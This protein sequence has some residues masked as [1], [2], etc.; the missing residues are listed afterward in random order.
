MENDHAY[1]RCMNFLAEMIEKYGPELLEEI[2]ERKQQELKD[3]K[4]S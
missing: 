1:I 4:V 2:E 3:K